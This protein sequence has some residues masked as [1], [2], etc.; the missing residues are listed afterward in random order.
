MPANHPSKRV[1][2]NGF[3]LTRINQEDRTRGLKLGS[4]TLR[5]D[6]NRRVGH[7][8]SGHGPFQGRPDQTSLAPQFRSS[9][10]ATLSYS[11]SG[12]RPPRTAR[13]RTREPQDNSRQITLGRELPLGCSSSLAGPVPRR[14]GGAGNGIFEPPS[15]PARSRARSEIVGQAPGSPLESTVNPQSTPTW[16]FQPRENR[17][18][19]L[20]QH[21]GERTEK[22]LPLDS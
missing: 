16:P 1:K 8:N 10:S 12:Y 7:W 4:A 21:A 17:R 9:S 14:I 3:L 2:S 5:Q 13:A 18:P 15:S 22:M 11:F 6:R 19:A 20:R